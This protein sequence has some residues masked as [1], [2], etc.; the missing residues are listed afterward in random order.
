MSLG[1]SP[2]FVRVQNDTWRIGKSIGK[3]III[4]PCVFSSV[5]CCCSSRDHLQVYLVKFG[6]IQN[7]KVKNLQHPIIL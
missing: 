6:N 7:K 2:S 3:S 5:L 4:F 1:T